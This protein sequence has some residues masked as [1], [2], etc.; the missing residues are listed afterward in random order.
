M[1]V[2]A[3]QKIVLRSR[4]GGAASGVTSV[5]ASIACSSRSPSRSLAGCGVVEVMGSATQA[6][7]PLREQPRSQPVAL[8]VGQDATFMELVQPALGLLG[9]AGPVTRRV[10]PAY[11]L[12]GPA[13]ALPVR[14]P[15]VDLIGPPRDGGGP[16]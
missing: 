12:I 7:R 2:T 14:E 16:H 5:R 8:A 4:R 1:P 9:V 10:R 6:P 15:R 11:Q 13:P 3:S